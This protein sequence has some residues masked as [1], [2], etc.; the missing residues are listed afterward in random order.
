[1]R[2]ARRYVVAALERGLILLQTLAASDTPLSLHEAAA[3][4]KIPKTTAFR[5]LATL[6]IRGFV[7]RT[8]EGAYG[9][10]PRMGRVAARKTGTIRRPV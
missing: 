10:G 4:A 5:L 3:F 9:I 8:R 6:E 1:M 2:D 7:S